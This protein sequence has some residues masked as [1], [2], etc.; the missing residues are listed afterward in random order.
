MLPTPCVVLQDLLSLKSSLTLTHAC[1]LDRLESI[2]AGWLPNF[3]P[4]CRLLPACSR[5]IDQKLF[6]IHTKYISVISVNFAITATSHILSR[7]SMGHSLNILL[8]RWGVLT[9]RDITFLNSFLCVQNWH[10]QSNVSFL[11]F[12]WAPIANKQPL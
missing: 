11:P 10:C 6:L 7:S 12:F 9:S 5:A 2:V 4:D 1:M 8:Q 3:Q